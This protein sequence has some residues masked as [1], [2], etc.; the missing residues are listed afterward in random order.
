MVLIYFF[1]LLL[2]LWSGRNMDKYFGAFVEITQFAT[3]IRKLEIS[4]KLI[5]ADDNKNKAD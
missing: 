2:T 3:I 5:E 4:E 1:Q